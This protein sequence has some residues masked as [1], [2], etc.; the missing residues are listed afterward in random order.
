VKIE[1]MVPP[2]PGQSP[3]QIIKERFIDDSAW[4]V[5]TSL[6]WTDYVERT[7]APMALHYAA[8]HLRYAVEQLWLKIFSAARGAL[9]SI[10]DYKRALKNATTLYKLI[11]SSTPDYKKFAE[12][13]QMIQQLDSSVHPPAVVWDIARLKKIHGEC[14]SRLLHLQESSETGYMS[15][16]WIADRRQFLNDSALW[17][18]NL[19]MTQGNIIV[20]YPD[21][22]VPEHDSCGRA[23]GAVKRMRKALKFDCS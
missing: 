6:R 19:M 13:D 7:E 1:A 10:Q 22:L 8:F 3:E 18:W 16:A 14:G 20:Y 9:V 15:S 4:H 23:F 11:D 12:F 21:G 17:M 2:I 5:M